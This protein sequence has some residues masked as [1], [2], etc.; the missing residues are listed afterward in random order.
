[1][2]SPNYPF[3]EGLADSNDLRGYPFYT[4]QVGPKKVSVLISGIHIPNHLTYEAQ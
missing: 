1:M 3:V 4:F 2:S